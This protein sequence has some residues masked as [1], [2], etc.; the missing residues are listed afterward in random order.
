MCATQGLAPARIEVI[1]NG[2][3]IA[4]VR[5]ADRAAARDELGAGPDAFVIGGVGQLI[6]RK[7]FHLAIEAAARLRSRADAAAPDVMVALVGEG[8]ERTALQELARAR[9][10]PLALAGYRADPA[11]FMAAFDVAVL[12]SRVEGMPMVLLE[13]MALGIACVATPAAG[14]VEVI[15]DGRSGF[16]VGFDDAAALAETLARLASDPTLRGR[17]GSAAAERIAARFSVDAMWSRYRAVL[18]R[19]RGHA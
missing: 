8:P 1:P 19:A 12:P 9:G 13:A 11:P 2:V 10:V 17:I 18:H 5:P 6:E 16:L 15:E 14:N 4:R 3:A 7:A